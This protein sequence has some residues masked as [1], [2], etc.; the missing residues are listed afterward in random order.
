SEDGDVALWEIDKPEPKR[1]FHDNEGAACLALDRYGDRLLVTGAGP[2]FRRW[3]YADHRWL[4]NKRWPG[5]ESGTAA[6][7]WSYDARFF[8]AGGLDGSV[9]LW[10][11]VTGRQLAMFTGHAVPVRAVAMTR[12]GML[13]LSGDDDGTVRLWD[14]LTSHELARF[15]DHKGA[16]LA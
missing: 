1:T 6:A 5:H 12:N 4:R 14:V 2:T 9:R 10:R 11:G 15:T 8:L 16:V 7:S 3:D 13:A